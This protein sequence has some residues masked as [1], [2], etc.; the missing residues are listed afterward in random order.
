[1]RL[2]GRVGTARQAQTSALREK[3][4]VRAT[5]PTTAAAAPPPSIPHLLEH[6]LNF[7]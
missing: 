6:R 3:R 4:T 1:G 7:R 2:P 5:T